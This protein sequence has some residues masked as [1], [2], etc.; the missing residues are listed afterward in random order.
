MIDEL[1]EDLRTAVGDDYVQHGPEIETFLSDMQGFYSGQALA[2]VKPGSTAEVAQI[3]KICARH[4]TAIVPQG[5]N[6]GL[7]GGAVPTGNQQAIILSMAR[8]NR[9][10]AVDP[11]RY[12]VTAEAGVIL[13][14]IHDAAEKADRAFAMD[15]GA[16]GS[17][18]VGGG[19][20]TN[21]GGLNVLQFGTARD[22]VLGLEVVLPDGRIWDGLRALRKDASGYDLKQLFIGSEGTLGIITKACLRLHPRQPVDQ[23]MFGAVSDL[24]RLMELFALARNIGGDALTAF[25]L[26]PGEGVRR[27]PE[28]KPA[29]SLPLATNADW[30]V[31]IRYSG[32]EAAEVE[33]RL[34]QLFEQAFADGLL[35]DAVVSQSI[36]QEANLW[37]LRDEIPPEK[38]FDGKLIKWDVSVPIDRV[39]E[40]LPLAKQLVEDL[41]PQGRF[42]AFGHVGDGNLHT[43]AFP[44]IEEGPEADALCAKLYARMDALI[45]SLDG[46][47]CAEHG[48]GIENVKR[49]TGQKSEIELELMS[50]IKA[51]LDP[52]GRMNPGKVI[53]A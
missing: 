4:G 21:A 36:A 13:Q 24:S 31:L 15:W 41:C 52:D 51:L 25:E 27:V 18:M 43:M 35:S 8:M 44:G 12:S 16:R 7:C 20:S 11:E 53:D 42:Y 39:T 37:H 17:A 45:W 28:V 46:S 2:V 19:I 3:V 50:S 23:S 33:Q 14:S 1:R 48:V 29:I 38:L 22:Q 9:I 49:L 26:L 40:F 10:L 47:I 5:G 6:T 30:C 34:T 32:R